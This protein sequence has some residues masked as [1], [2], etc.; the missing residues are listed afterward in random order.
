MTDPNPLEPLL[1][2]K[3]R[4]LAIQKALLTELAAALKFWEPN[5]PSL[6]RLAELR[7]QK[8][9]PEGM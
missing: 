3:D 4:Q 5:H 9:T 7:G 1:A 2:K 6:I 8:H